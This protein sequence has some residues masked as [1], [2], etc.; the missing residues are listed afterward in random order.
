[1]KTNNIMNYRDNFNQLKTC[2]LSA[3]AKIEY[4]DSEMSMTP[5]ERDYYRDDE[6][7]TIPDDLFGLF[8]SFDGLTFRW[9]LETNEGKL[10]GFFQFSLFLDLQDN[11]TENKL[12]VD[13]YEADDIEEIKKH[14]IF[15]MFNGMDYY[16]T[17]I[18]GEGNDYSLYYVPEGS[19][20]L[21]GSKTLSKIPLTIEQYIEIV[22]GYYGV[23]SVRHHLHKPEFYKNPEQFIPEHDL[24][25]KMIPNFNPPKIQLTNLS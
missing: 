14:R 4:E 2:L 18:F 3:H 17:I 19:V 23:Y 25:K 11:E 7:F 8:E 22:F 10:S 20:N 12:W 5:G 1:M 15:E 21:G 13:W 9:S 24:L 6:G 16:V